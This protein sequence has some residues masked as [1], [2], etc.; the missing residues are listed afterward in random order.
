MQDILYPYKWLKSTPWYHNKY[1]IVQV[2]GKSA[3]REKW[4]ARDN[5]ATASHMKSQVACQ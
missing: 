1:C 5:E 2:I 3:A 4:P